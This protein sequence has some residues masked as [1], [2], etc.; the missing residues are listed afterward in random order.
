MDGIPARGWNAGD[1]T[2][3][4]DWKR[5]FI[6]GLGLL[7]ALVH[8]NAAPRCHYGS[9]SLTGRVARVYALDRSSFEIRLV[10]G[11]CLRNS[12]RIPVPENSSG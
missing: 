11:T 12:W 2:D 3:H 4:R 10:V 8:V 6:P 1:V 7:A 5:Y 9:L